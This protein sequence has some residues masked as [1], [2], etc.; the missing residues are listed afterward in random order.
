MFVNFQILPN[1]YDIGQKLA[2]FFS[3]KDHT[4]NGIPIVAQQ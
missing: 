4:I 1:K 3:I 2:L